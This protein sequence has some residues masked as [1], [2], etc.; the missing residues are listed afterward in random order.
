M[1]VYLEGILKECS[2]LRIVVQ[3]GGIGYEVHIPISTTERLPA[4]G[5]TVRLHTVALYREDSQTLYGFASVPERDTFRLFLDKV[6]GIGPKTALSIL[7]K[8]SISVLHQA[9]LAGDVKILS[10]CPGIG[11]KTAERLIIEL[12]DLLGKMYASG[13]NAETCSL[14]PQG[15]LAPEHASPVADAVSAL[16]TLGY[17]L[18]DADKAVRKALGSLDNPED[19]S[20]ENL[21]KKALASL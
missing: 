3:Q 7:S 21:I 16:V 15:L 9:I 14:H 11:K 1:I 17:K 4:V 20:T 6:S 13:Q 2:P 12:K 8:L 18:S 10:Q 19:P 5:Q